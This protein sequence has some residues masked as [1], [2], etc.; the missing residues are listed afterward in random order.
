M[1][2]GS[3]TTLGQAKIGA[4]GTWSFVT[5]KRLELGAHDFGADQFDEATGLV[6]GRASV[7]MK[8][9][10]PVPVV[11]AQEPTPESQEAAPGTPALAAQESG[12]ESGDETKPKV[13]EV[14]PGDTLWDIAERFFGGG[15]RYK[16]I[17]NQN[18]K[19]IRKPGLIYPEQQFDLP[20][21]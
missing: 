1:L 12:Q 5:E 19:R 21:E 9:T 2:V 3:F 16:K 14:R 18:R 13:Y 7:G 4:D 15:W 10:L 8:R 17:Y 6:V 11:A 20:D